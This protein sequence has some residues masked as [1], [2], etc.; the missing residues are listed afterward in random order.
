MRMT[1]SLAARARGKTSP[2]PLVGSVIVKGGEVIARAYHKRAGTPHA[3][4]LALEEAGQKARGATLYVNLE[5]CSHTDKRTPP[6]ADAIITA[7]VKR[8]VVSMEDPNPKVSGRGFRKLR[9]AGIQVVSGVLDT[10]ARKL[11]EAY[12]KHVTTGMP[13]VILKTAMTLD[14]KIATPEGQSKWI[15]GEKARALVHRTRASVDA[16]I[17]A[18]G[19]VKADDPRM[20]A[21]VR[22]AKSPLRVVIDPRLEISPDAEIL[23]MPPQT[24]IVTS[25]RGEKAAQLERIGVECLFFDGSL[26]LAWLLRELGGK[27]MV[28]VLLEGGA[29]L[30]GHAFFEGVVDRAMFF[31][32][33]RVIGGSRS[34][35]AVGGD[36]FRTLQNACRLDEI[37]VRRLGDDILVEGRV[38]CPGK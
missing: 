17:T 13:F 4:A 2:N 5:P 12:I 21:R 16:I 14:G 38:T 26:S 27:G 19:T 32:A 7:G 36:G 30:N 22:G 29:S 23:R 24:L 15:T 31:I 8:V 20:T 35:P 34:F 18:I 11:N 9:D 10:E 1:L 3:E 37:K 33:P 6:C 25:R 28:S